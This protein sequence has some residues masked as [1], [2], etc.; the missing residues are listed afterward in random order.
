MSAVDSDS[1]QVAAE[2]VNQMMNEALLA[3]TAEQGRLWMH[4]PGFLA[5][6]KRVHE[7]G[8]HM[9]AWAT[10]LIA[11]STRLKDVEGAKDAAEKTAMLAAIALGDVELN[12]MLCRKLYSRR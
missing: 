11:L 9:K 3:C 7:S 6:G 8:E 2:I 1:D 10:A 4:E 5:I 12:G